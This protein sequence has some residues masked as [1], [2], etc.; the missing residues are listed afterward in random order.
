MLLQN[1]LLFSS[2]KVEG[3][4]KNSY[5]APQT[6]ELKMVHSFKTQCISNPA[7]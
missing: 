3:G 2:T 6:P 4:G 5:S 7:P 1:V